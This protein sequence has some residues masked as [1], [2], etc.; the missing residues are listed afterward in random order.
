MLFYQT[1]FT[2]E[3]TNPSIRQINHYYDNYF[4]VTRVTGSFENHLTG[5]FIL[6]RVTCC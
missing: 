4:T 2:I 3:T 6:Q 5:C 1:M